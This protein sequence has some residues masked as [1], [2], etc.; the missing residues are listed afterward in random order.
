M[1]ES[2]ADWEVRESA[3]DSVRKVVLP[4]QI[5]AQTGL[6]GTVYRVCIAVRGAQN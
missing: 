1:T 5:S 3:Y 2:A 4:A 6:R